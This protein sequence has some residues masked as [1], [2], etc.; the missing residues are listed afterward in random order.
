MRT[1]SSVDV[2]V[3]IRDKDMGPWL[4]SERLGVREIQITRRIHHIVHLIGAGQ[5]KPR[6]INR[7]QALAFDNVSDFSSCP[8]FTRLH[9][10]LDLGRRGGEKMFDRPN[11]E[12]EESTTLSRRTITRGTVLTL[13]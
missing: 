5:L 3:Q 10:A 1:P 9:R 7:P 4:E 12:G 8:S 2:K 6:R 13:D 11:G